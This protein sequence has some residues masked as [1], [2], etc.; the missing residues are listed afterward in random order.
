MLDDVE[1]HHEVRARRADRE[2]PGVAA[3]DLGAIRAETVRGEGLLGQPHRVGGVFDA[4][5]SCRPSLHS[6]REELPPPRA[7]V[8]D[9]LSGAQPR[10]LE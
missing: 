1:H 10:E 2:A 5:R 7:H 4:D 8:D 6:N 3:D 9:D